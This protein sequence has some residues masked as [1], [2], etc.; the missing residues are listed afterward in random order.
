MR[1]LGVDPGSVSWDFYGCEIEGDSRVVFFD[2]TLSSSSIKANPELVVN[3]IKE[4]LPLDAIAAPS[5]FGLPLRDISNISQH[6]ISLI[7]LHSSKEQAIMG[8]SQ[9]LY[10]LKEVSIELSI[11]IYIIPGVKHFSTV[12]RY[13]KI[14]IIDM[15]TADKVCNVVQGI[16]QI[17]NEKDLKFQEINYIMLEIGRGFSAA[18]A[19]EHGKIIDGIGGSNLIGFKSL[20][21]MDSELVFLGKDHIKSKKSIYQGGIDSMLSSFALGYLNNKNEDDKINYGSREANLPGYKMFKQL[22]ENSPIKLILIEQ[23][24]KALLQLADS[25]HFTKISSFYRSSSNY[26]ILVLLTGLGVDLQWLKMKLQKRLQLFKL[27]ESPLFE[28]D[29]LKSYSKQAKTAAQGACLIAEGIL[30]GPVQDL[31][32]HMGLFETKG[33]ILDDIYFPFEEFK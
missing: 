29:Y 12:P 16:H 22:A 28:F 19:V 13:R 3:L 17:S 6:E 2:F 26:R 27:G 8:L 10:L 24:A 30:G 15:G 31:L 21:R 33:T 18:V 25:F 5:G 7:T 20:G 4:Q 11:P 32:D 9:V 1:V 23:I 14:N